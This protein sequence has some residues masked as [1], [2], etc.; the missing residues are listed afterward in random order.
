MTMDSCPVYG[1]VLI[2]ESLIN[3]H[4]SM[5]RMS[6]RKNTCVLLKEVAAFQM[7]LLMEVFL[8]NVYA[9]ACI[10]LKEFFVARYVFPSVIL[11]RPH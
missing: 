9:H 4:M 8:Y 6:M 5:Q 10:L 1:G 7:C 3:M 11:N 2:S